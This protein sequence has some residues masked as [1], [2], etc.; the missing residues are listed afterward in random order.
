MTGLPFHAVLHDDDRVRTT[1]VSELLA[2]VAGPDVRVVRVGNPLRSPLTLD[3]ILM[4]VAGPDGDIIL[5]Q[6][7][8]VVQAITRRQAQET[9]VLLVIE[10]A[11]TLHPAALRSLQAMTPHFKQDGQPALRVAF[12][13][14]T[15]FRDLLAGEDLAPMR[16]ALGIPDKANNPVTLEPAPPVMAVRQTQPAAPASPEPA[17]PAVAAHEALAEPVPARSSRWLLRAVLVLVLLGGAVAASIQGLRSLF[18]RDVP[19]RPALATVIPAPAL[20]P[21]P[22]P[23][24]N[25][26]AVVPT[27][28]L[29]PAPALL[30]PEPVPPAPLPPVAAPT[31]A[32]VLPAVITPPPPSPPT[33]QTARLRRDF[34]TFLARSGRGTATLT[35]AQRA[36]LFDEFLE[37]RAQ[38]PGNA[39]P[40]E[41]GPRI[42]IHVPAGS[43]EAGTVSNQLLAMLRPRPGTVEARPVADGPARPTINFYHPDDEAAARQAA[44][45]MADAGLA[46][47]VRDLTSFQPRPPRGL[48]E[49]WLPDR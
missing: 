44:G 18:Y 15:A 12:V 37:W 25:P 31:P 30:P 43:V 45:W 5:G 17:R 36:I 4:Q 47:T 38:N 22:D 16:A 14:R 40:R 23:E 41:P 20:T 27:T 6:D 8:T 32:P 42:I 9:R 2:S 13:G 26:P 48:I 34:E 7:A 3:R 21:Q 19:P 33:D 1:A 46:W 28:P 10:Q 49:V 29:L 24:P 39:N 35:D 11:D